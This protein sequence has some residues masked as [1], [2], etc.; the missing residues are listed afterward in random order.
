M[1]PRRS[2]HDPRSKP[3]LPLNPNLATDWLEIHHDISQAAEVKEWLWRRL[4]RLT[5]AGLD[6]S[7]YGEITRPACSWLCRQE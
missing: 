5:H 1:P 3:S 6:T 2:L 7:A 4:P